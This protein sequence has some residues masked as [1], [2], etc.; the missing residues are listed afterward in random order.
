MDNIGFMEIVL[1]GIIAILLYGKDLPQAARKMAQLY[2]K[3]RRQLNDVRDELHRQIPTEDITLPPDPPENPHPSDEV[4]DSTPPG[5][6]Q[7][8]YGSPAP[9]AENPP[10]G[11]GGG[12]GSPAPETPPP[13]GDPAKTATSSSG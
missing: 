1:I 5:E 8:E 2:G 12:S 7:D 13:T 11:E 3:F 4:T 10:A 9:A 6:T